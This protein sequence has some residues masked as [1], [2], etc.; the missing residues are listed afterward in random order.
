MRGPGGLKFLCHVPPTLLF[1]TSPH[2]VQFWA[3]RS[4]SGSFCR[5]TS[6]CVRGAV[7]LPLALSRL[8]SASVLERRS[9]LPLRFPSLPSHILA[10]WLCCLFIHRYKRL[11]GRT[12]GSVRKATRTPLH[13]PWCINRTFPETL[14]CQW[15]SLLIFMSGSNHFSVAS[16]LFC[17]TF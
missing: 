6:P 15:H 16:D 11:K 4:R 12:V 5:V 17:F 13:W 10:G 7:T 8:L 3:F 1:N 9:S 14:S 2:L